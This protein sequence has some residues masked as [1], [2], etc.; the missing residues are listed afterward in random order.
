[1]IEKISLVTQYTAEEPGEKFRTVHPTGHPRVG[2]PLYASVTYSEKR[3]RK[4]WGA[5][6][7]EKMKTKHFCGCAKTIYYLKINVSNNVLLD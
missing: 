6:V 3:T 1:M 4:V 7:W 2:A 5:S